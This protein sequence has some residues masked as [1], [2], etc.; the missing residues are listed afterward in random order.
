MTRS[1]WSS[2]RSRCGSC[3]PSTS[4]GDKTPIVIGSAL[5]A[6][7]GDTSPMGE[8]A[9][10]KLADALDSYIPTPKR[11]IDKPFSDAGGG[12]CSPSQEEAR[13]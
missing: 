11:E 13:W 5:K 2:L 10:M 6:L 1:S 9:I 8:G 4:S 12:T 3:S 7:E